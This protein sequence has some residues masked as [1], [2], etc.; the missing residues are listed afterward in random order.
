[1]VLCLAFAMFFG[2]IARINMIMIAIAF[3]GVLSKGIGDYRSP[4]EKTGA[5]NREFASMLSM[6]AGAGHIYLNKTINGTLLLIL[7]IT[8]VIGSGYGF[9][10]VVGAPIENIHNGMIVFSYSIIFTLTLSVW[11]ML[12]VNY[13]CDRLDVP[14][15]GSI[16]E[17]KWKNTKKGIRLL[18][19]FSFTL[20]FLVS[21]A[22]VYYDLLSPKIGIPIILISVML[23]VLSFPY[24]NK[25]TLDSEF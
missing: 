24:S 18:S 2:G 3:A 11:S 7:F 20:I 12:S 19:V 16:Y 23:F 1:M 5:K 8:S 17:M 15:S 22:F 14:R 6:F 21:I 25:F 10:T 4:E 13:I 9:F